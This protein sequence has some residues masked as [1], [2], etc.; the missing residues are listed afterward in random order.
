[1]VNS[2]KRLEMIKK[3]WV[4]VLLGGI[5]MLTFLAYSNVLNGE[6]QF[7]D[8]MTIENNSNIK[9]IANMFN[10]KILL[11]YFSGGR[12]VTDFTF[13]LN[14]YYGRLD[15]F[16]YHVVNIIIHLVVVVLVF[17]AAGKIF[18]LSDYSRN[19]A[20]IMGL[21]ASAIFGFHP[22]NTQAVSYISQRAESLS[23]L[24]YLMSLLVFIRLMETDT[25]KK[26]RLTPSLTLP[27]RGG[28]KGGGL[29]LH[30]TRYTLYAV[31]I[32]FFLLALGSKLTAISLPAMLLLYQIYFLKER[33]FYKKLA[34]VLPFVIV[35]SLSGAL[36]I[37]SL[38][39][40]Q[41]IG[42]SIKGITFEQYFLT[43]LRVII[44]YMRLIIAP[45]NQNFD[46]DYTIYNSFFDLPVVL[47]FLFHIS[48]I[49]LA[50]YLYRRSESSDTR[51]ISFGIV[52][53]FITLMPTSSFVPVR[54]VI[55]EHRL[56]LP[57]IGMI[58]S[59][60]VAGKKILSLT[61]VRY[62]TLVSAILIAS[63]L[64]SLAI[65][66]Y[67][68]NYVWSSKIT[69]LQD[70]VSKSPNKTR[71]HTAL[72]DAFSAKGLY[73]EAVDEYLKALNLRDDGRFERVKILNGLGTVYFRLGRI[74]EA[75]RIFKEEGISKNLFDKDL[76]NNM[77]IALMDRGRDDEALYYAKKALG[78]GT[79]GSEIYNTIGEIY[80][81]KGDNKKAFEYFKE[82]IRINPD[83]PARYW[84]AALSLE[85]LGRKCEAHSYWKQYIDIEKNESDRKE[86]IE[87][88]QKL[89][90]CDNGN[91][92]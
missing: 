29:R 22:I 72:G 9:S 31:S 77:A 28:G 17:L 4:Y 10:L 13:A 57:A 92:E 21:I 71:A 76:L 24:F 87:H 55:F 14:Y 16:S 86:A 36:F 62:R 32:M 79:K 12:P 34:Y 42:F 60:V 39:A 1:M 33:P 65:A 20:E 82:A 89:K 68:R 25:G 63:V 84:N 38:G 41:D 66:T 18:M 73:R 56:Y 26:T 47:S 81:K 11:S 19:E 75:I 88:M 59:L 91:A 45:V 61:S 7:D 23:A 15:V 69:L 67:K 90:G 27:P 78:G 80:L 49:G 54:D 50:I 6:F 37:A 30:A 46:Y 40:S 74:D 58:L 64:S 52:W 2:F 53:F 70:V 35:V 3:Y 51:V 48:L 83:V 8:M 85:R 5:L 43:Q 44:T